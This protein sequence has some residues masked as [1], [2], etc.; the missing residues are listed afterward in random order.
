ML[1][2]VDT[3]K[4]KDFLKITHEDITKRDAIR[5]VTE[6]K[7]ELGFKCVNSSWYLKDTMEIMQR[8]VKNKME[9]LTDDDLLW[10]HDEYIMAREGKDEIEIK[11]LVHG[12]YELLFDAM[13]GVKKK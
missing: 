11:F 8:A 13:L 6:M 5:I 9:V 10:R 12:Y 2:L 7:R 4:V 1:R 3:I